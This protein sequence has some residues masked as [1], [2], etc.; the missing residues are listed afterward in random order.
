MAVPCG[1]SFAYIFL[2]T[3]EVTGSI[4][5]SPTV[6]IMRESPPKRGAAHSTEL[7]IQLAILPRSAT[8]VALP[9]MT[10]QTRFLFPC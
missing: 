8:A 1:T 6:G 7:A 10:R 3:E 4:P 5:V 9:A 2:H